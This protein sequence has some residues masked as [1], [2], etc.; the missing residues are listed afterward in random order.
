MCESLYHQQDR[1][2]RGIDNLRSEL[3]NFEDR[4]KRPLVGLCSE[5]KI[6]SSRKG[7]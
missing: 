7:Y 6:V 4:L 5:K 3:R 2:H 1:I